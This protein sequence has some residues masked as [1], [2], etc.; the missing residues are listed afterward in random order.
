[1]GTM[2]DYNATRDKRSPVSRSS[3]SGTGEDPPYINV[4]YADFKSRSKL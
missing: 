1:M 3:G 4:K 2:Q